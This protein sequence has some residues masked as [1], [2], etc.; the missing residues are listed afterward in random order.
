M[1]FHELEE[2]NMHSCYQTPIYTFKTK[3]ILCDG[4]LKIIWLI[5]H[6]FTNI[7]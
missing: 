5:E 6:S 3:E 2:K 4:V 7:T 1:Q